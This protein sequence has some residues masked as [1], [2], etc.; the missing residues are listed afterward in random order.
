MLIFLIHFSREEYNTHVV[1]MSLKDII[2][3][4]QLKY[5]IQLLAPSEEQKLLLEFRRDH[6]LEDALRHARK[7][8]FSPEKSL[9]VIF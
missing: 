2:H 6:V 4:L 7:K 9:K 1:M 3:V 5:D 8:K